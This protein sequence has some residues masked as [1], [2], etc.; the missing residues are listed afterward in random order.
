MKT[1]ELGGQEVCPRCFELI[2]YSGIISTTSPASYASNVS[3]FRL[4]SQ[5]GRAREDQRV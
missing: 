5:D 2:R 3:E 1:G 4:M